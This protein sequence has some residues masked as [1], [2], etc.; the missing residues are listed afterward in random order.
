MIWCFWFRKT[1]SSVHIIAGSSVQP[2]GAGAVWLFF[3]QKRE[4][5]HKKIAAPPH[6]TKIRYFV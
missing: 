1:V 2:S 5:R 6:R 4:V 3:G